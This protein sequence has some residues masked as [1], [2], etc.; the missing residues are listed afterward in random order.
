MSL[1]VRPAVR[2][3]ARAIATIRVETWRAAY[4][5]LIADEVLDRLDVDRE[6]ERRRS[7]WAENHAD[8]RATELIAEV[9]GE[10]AGW[11][12]VGASRDDDARD[13]GEV[14]AIYA[15]ERFW[16]TGVGHALLAASEDFLRDAGF[17]AALLWYL[18][19]NDRAARFYERHGW[20]E[21]GA[22]KQ[23]DRLVGGVSAHALTERRRRRSLR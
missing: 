9:D 19:G 16:S 4:G 8:P 10:V 14:Y 22:V 6:A 5:G 3:D 18:D 20:T 21:D 12:A 23:D 2:T 17:D 1:V 13:H 11:A 7:R 15:L